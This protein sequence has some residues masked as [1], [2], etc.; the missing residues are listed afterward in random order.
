[1]WFCIV[2]LKIC[3]N[4]LWKLGFWNV[5]LNFVVGIGFFLGSWCLWCWCFCWVIGFLGWCWWLCL[6]LGGFVFW[7]NRCVVVLKGICLIWWIW[8]FY[9]FLFVFVCGFVLEIVYEWWCF[10]SWRF[11]GLCW[12][13][14]WRLVLFFWWFLF[15][16]GWVCRCL[17]V[18]V[19]V[20]ICWFCCVW[21][22]W[23]GYLGLVLWWCCVMFW[24]W[25]CWS[26]C[27]WWCCLFY[28]GLFFLVNVIWCWR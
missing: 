13:L 27:V 11:W 10:C 17:K 24:W 4:G 19:V 22:D 25:W 26:C 20:L 6:L 1:M 28:L 8:W 3:W 16:C 9:L 7:W 12:C 15:S 21:L 18:G 23:F 5:W 2:E 14:D